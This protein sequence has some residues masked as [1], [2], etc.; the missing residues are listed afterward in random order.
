M[1]TKHDSQEIRVF[2]PYCN[3]LTI[4]YDEYKFNKKKIW[5]EFNK[6]HYVDTVCMNPECDSNGKKIKLCLGHFAKKYY[7]AKGQ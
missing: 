4:G 3:M 2:C 6:Y 1:I 7:E 5:S